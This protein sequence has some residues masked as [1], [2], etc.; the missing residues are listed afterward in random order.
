MPRTIDPRFLR[1]R[2]TTPN[3]IGLVIP[4]NATM[5]PELEERFNAAKEYFSNLSGID[6]GEPTGISYSY[7]Y[8]DYPPD[9]ALFADGATIDTGIYE[10]TVR[11][12]IIGVFDQPAFEGN[13][14]YWSFPT[15]SQVD[16]LAALRIGETFDVDFEEEL[17]EA[18]HVVRYHF[19]SGVPDSGYG[20]YA[21]HLG[22]D[23]LSRQGFRVVSAY[24]PQSKRTNS[25]LPFFFGFRVFGKSKEDQGYPVWRELLGQ[26][27]REILFGRWHYSLLY[28]AFSLE[29]FIDKRLAD[30]LDKSGVGD[31]YIEHALRVGEKESELHALNAPENR[32]S[33]SKVQSTYKKLNKHIFKHRNNLAHGRVPGT[34]ITEEIA[35]QAIRTAVEFVWDWDRSARPLLLV[36]MSP[37]SFEA[38]IDDELIKSCQD[39]V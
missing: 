6:P 5:K 19:P 29:S 12:A 30:M 35:V 11:D 39:E 18:Y 16:V 27:V 17:E 14:F 21:V 37:G 32:F 13:D 31:V 23:P 4:D 36:Q 7:H 33:K 2:I 28:T 25:R 3:R 1:Q 8:I 26:A 15:T 24:E 22:I 9:E 20:E 38:M 34:D 10:F